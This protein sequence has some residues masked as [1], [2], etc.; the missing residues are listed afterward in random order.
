M[1]LSLLLN[2]RLLIEWSIN[3]DTYSHRQSFKHVGKNTNSCR[4]CDMWC[5]ATTVIQNVKIW[6]SVCMC[7]TAWMYGLFLFHSAQLRAKSQNK[8]VWTSLHQTRLKMWLPQPGLN[9]T[10]WGELGSW[11]G[12]GGNSLSVFSDVSLKFYFSGLSP[13]VDRRRCKHIAH[14]GLNTYSHHMG[15]DSWNNIP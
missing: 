5:V 4:V 1:F 10:T 13:M 8:S 14:S 9:E 15:N 7:D 12:V 3:K 2:D 6:W 11:A